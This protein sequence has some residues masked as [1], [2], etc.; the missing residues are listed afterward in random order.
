MA[1]DHSA[2]LPVFPRSKTSEKIEN[3]KCDAGA[4]CDPEAELQ[5]R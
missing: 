5:R 2:N 4:L 3:R 1:V